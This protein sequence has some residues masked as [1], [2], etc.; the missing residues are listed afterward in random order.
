MQE[1][2]L[3]PGT[4]EKEVESKWDSPLARLDHIPADLLWRY[5]EGR[6]NDR[7][8]DAVAR[9]L[10]QNPEKA[11]EVEIMRK[12]QELLDKID[13]SIL[14]EPVPEKLKSVIEDARRRLNRNGD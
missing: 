12:Q 3:R 10:E 5:V 7:Q 11:R 14:D 8:H 1:P 2:R 4:L 6:L 9:Y 13:A